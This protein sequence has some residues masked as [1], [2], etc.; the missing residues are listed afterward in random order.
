MTVCEKYQELISG[1][2]DGELTEAEYTAVQAHIA[3]CD[4]CRAM[5][6][7][8]MELDAVLAEA[9][10]VPAALHENIM[11]GVKSAAVAKK[12][13]GKIYYFRRAAAAAACL[14]LVV[15]AAFAAKELVPGRSEMDAA[16][17]G[18]MVPTGATEMYSATIGGYGAVE[19]ADVCV[20][21]SIAMAEEKAIEDSVMESQSVQSGGA[22]SDSLPIPMPEPWGKKD[23][24][25]W[26]SARRSSG[27]AMIPVIDLDALAQALLPAQENG[28]MGETDCS[29]F[30]ITL[31][32]TQK[33]GVLRTLHICV[34]DSQVFVEEDGSVYPAACTP[35]EFAA[36][37]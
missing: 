8:F 23:P 16:A 14:V 26:I 6:E 18:A 3:L 22:G 24:S 33:D 17:P 21:T 10:E 20:N 1:M 36:I 19:D 34:T 11:T 31:E 37:K 2:L 4:R 5:Y 13:S 7:A 15:G 9:E 25:V 27:S 35:A 32:I 29:N 12:R 28:T 30:D